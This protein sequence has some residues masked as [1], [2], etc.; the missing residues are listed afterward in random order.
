[1]ANTSILSAFE[2]MWAHIIAALENKADSS[3]DH[4]GVYCTTES[5]LEIQSSISDVNAAI[6][7]IKDVPECASA[8]NGKFLRVVDGSAAWSTV[9]IAE[10]ATF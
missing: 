8:D 1:M 6:D 5:I 3:H 9:P 2:R 4:N 10:E 7:S